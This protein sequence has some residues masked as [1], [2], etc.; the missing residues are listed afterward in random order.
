MKKVLII[1]AIIFTGLMLLLIPAIIAA[2]AM[3]QR[4]QCQTREK[5]IALAVNLYE[6]SHKKFPP[7]CLTNSEGKD[8]Y[9]FLVAV[10]PQLDME[11]LWNQLDI[12]RQLVQFLREFRERDGQQLELV[13][14]DQY[15]VR[16]RQIHPDDLTS[17]P[18]RYKL[19]EATAAVEGG[20]EGP[21]EE[22]IRL[23]KL[24][25]DA[26]V[27]VKKVQIQSILM[28]SRKPAVLIDGS[29]YSIGD[30]VAGDWTLVEICPYDIK[31]QWHTDNKVTHFVPLEE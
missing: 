18:F 3:A 19:T 24:K 9:S 22:E 23:A 25:E 8:G 6:S 29:M 7:S 15:D 13:D 11:R 27:R 14:T 26:L 28:S 10:L 20:V 30:S 17:N 5:N 2:R 31:L 4:M 1:L 16:L 21:S 12:D